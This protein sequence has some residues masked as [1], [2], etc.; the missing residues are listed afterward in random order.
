MSTD[1]KRH[2]SEETTDSLESVGDYI[3][4]PPDG[5]WGWV[6]V[7]SS[8]MCNIIVDGLGYSFGVLL[9]QWVEVFGE[10]PGKISLIGALLVGVYLCAGPVVSGLTNK[11][12][13]RPVTFAG[14]ILACA[15]FLFASFSNSV[16][17]LC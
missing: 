6:I 9:P 2:D 3:P 15:G 11:F 14:S 10:S 1:R 17:A 4:T 8:L 16:T 5:G 13:C 7:F 12:G